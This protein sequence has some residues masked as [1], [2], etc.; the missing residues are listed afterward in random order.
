MRCLI[1]LVILKEARQAILDPWQQL[2]Q[3]FKIK[4][5]TD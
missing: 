2:T 3:K 4:V 5:P 1:K